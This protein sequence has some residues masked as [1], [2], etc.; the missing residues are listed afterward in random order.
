MQR[1]PQMNG[2]APTVQEG[3]AT[4]NHTKAQQERVRVES[5]YHSAEEG[6]KKNKD[7]A[8]LIVHSNG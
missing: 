5:I 1:A 4:N 3:R 8:S 2:Q 6:N 7:T